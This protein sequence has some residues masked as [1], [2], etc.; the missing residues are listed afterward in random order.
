MSFQF[1]LAQKAETEMIRN[2]IPEKYKWNLNDIYKDWRAWDMAKKEFTS[3]YNMLDAAKGTFKNPEQLL[4]VLD[5]QDS[6]VA[7]YYRLEAYPGLLLYIDYDNK[8][9]P[10]KS[11]ELSLLVQE[12][13]KAIEW[14]DPELKRIPLLTLQEWEKSYPKI[15]VHRITEKMSGDEQTNMDEKE[16]NCKLKLKTLKNIPYSIYFNLSNRDFKPANI[17]LSGGDDIVLTDQN[18]F[19]ILSM[20]T[21]RIDRRKAFEAYHQVNKNNINTYAA[22]YNSVL[23]TDWAFAQADNQSS[24]LDAAAKEYNITTRTYENLITNARKG[25]SALLKYH[26]LRAGY[27]G[28]D[29]YEPFDM[30]LKL[31][32]ID[33]KFTY[34]EAKRILINAVKPLGEVYMQ[35]MQMVLSDGWVDVYPSAKKSKLAEQWAFFGTHPYILINFDGSVS[36]MIDMA[37]EAGHAVHHMLSQENQP[38]TCWEPDVQTTEMAAILTEN[39]LIYYL[40]EYLSN[41]EDKLAILEDNIRTAIRDFY[42]QSQLADFEY[43]AHRIVENGGLITPD[44]L[45]FIMKGIYKS[46][47]DDIYNDNWSEVTWARVRHFYQV[48]FYIHQYAL[49]YAGT[50]SMLERIIQDSSNGKSDPQDQ[51]LNILKS[52]NKETPSE[53]L[54]KAGID[55]E[56]PETILLAIQYFSRLVS[57]FEKEIAKI[58]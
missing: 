9:A 15:A 40:Y 12:S 24:C 23:K 10:E 25:V 17:K 3:L 27:M 33:H 37:H 19:Q 2:E 22:I 13:K 34:D 43:Q 51:Y 54:M 26:N 55:L 38:F 32:R 29:Q 21:N 31:F 50:T 30:S 56:K 53:L 57:L 1:S 14:I 5:L 44:T 18:Y 49:G 36:S 16:T 11:Q 35:K 8:E 48:P 42:F 4:R 58:K 45:N 46:Y 28:I 41:P 20:D 47:Y 7:L 39:L 52:G 6:M